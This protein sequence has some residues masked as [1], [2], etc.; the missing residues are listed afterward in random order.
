MAVL[1]LALII[2][3]LVLAAVALIATKG[4]SLVAWAVGALGVALFLLHDGKLL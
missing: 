3:A 1:P 4:T 2:V